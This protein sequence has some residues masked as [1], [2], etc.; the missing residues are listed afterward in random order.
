MTTKTKEEPATAI[1]AAPKKRG[2]GSRRKAGQKAKPAENETKNEEIAASDMPSEVP[3]ETP[4][5]AMA[6]GVQEEAAYL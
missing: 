1:A 6:E 2:T 3:A 5:P 4:A